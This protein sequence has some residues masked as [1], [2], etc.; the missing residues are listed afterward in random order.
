LLTTKLG[1]KESVVGFYGFIPFLQSG[2]GQLKTNGIQTA[3]AVCR[4]SPRIAAARK[5]RNKNEQYFGQMVPDHH[6]IKPKEKDVLTLPAFLFL[7]L[8]HRNGIDTD[9]GA[10][11]SNAMFYDSVSS[12]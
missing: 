8:L 5:K 12:S 7:L 10:P 1:I 11:E 3:W 9:D 2:F 4:W 6:G